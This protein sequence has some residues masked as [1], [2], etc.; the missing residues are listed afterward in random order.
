[1]SIAP[2]FLRHALQLFVTFTDSV[3][4]LSE[5]TY[6]FAMSHP[7]DT[8]IEQYIYGSAGFLRRFLMRRHF[9]GCPECRGRLE[10]AIAEREDNQRVYAAI[11][12]YE[13]ADA[14]AEKT[15][16]LPKM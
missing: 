4:L 3:T 1:M 10:S 6:I 15:M 8:E 7:T 16:H 13:E 12:R 5:K 14:E 2:G 11:R 9:T